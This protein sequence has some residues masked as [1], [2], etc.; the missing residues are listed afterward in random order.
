M[1]MFMGLVS[2]MIK[3]MV[4]SSSLVEGLGTLQ[5]GIR[6]QSFLQTSHFVLLG[7]YMNTISRKKIENPLN[8]TQ[9]NH[10]PQCVEFT[11]EQ[12]FAMTSE[13]KEKLTNTQVGGIGLLI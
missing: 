9:D 2:R 10:F 12:K 13:K 4:A 5:C 3:A 1:H 6:Y 11:T 8:G 7:K